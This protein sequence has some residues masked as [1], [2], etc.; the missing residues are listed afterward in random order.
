M[1]FHLSNEEETFNL[2]AKGFSIGKDLVIAI[3]GGILPHVG[4]VGIAHPRPRLKPAIL[5]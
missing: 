2:E 5:V 4:A 3:F 1:E